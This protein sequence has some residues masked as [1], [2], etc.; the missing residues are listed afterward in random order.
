[1]ATVVKM[2]HPQ[3]GVEK[4][5]FFGFSWTTLFFGGFPT[6]LRGDLII[7][8]W[9]LIAW[10]ATFG[11]AGLVWA[12]IYNKTYTQRLLGQ[13][14]VF[15]DSKDVNEMAGAALGVD[16][17]A[18]SPERALGDAPTV[19]E[20]GLA[21]AAHVLVQENVLG[22]AKATLGDAAEEATSDLLDVLLD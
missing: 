6:I 18:V 1:M 2:K 5:G 16:S 17:S 10:I 15:A 3:T 21:E 13:G 20:V 11:L 19:A 12:F 8:L 4:E 7:G 9:V 22:G 14:Y